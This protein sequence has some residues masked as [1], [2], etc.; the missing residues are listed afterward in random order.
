MRVMQ[1]N[2]KT[3]DDLQAK[4]EHLVTHSDELMQEM[5]D[6]QVG[7]L[8][9]LCGKTEVILFKTTLHYYIQKRVSSAVINDSR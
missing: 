3:L 1:Q 4:M 9:L 5:D 6:L 2:L 8:C 7:V